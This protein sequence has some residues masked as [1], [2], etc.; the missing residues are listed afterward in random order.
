[1]CGAVC[2]H[3]FDYIKLRQMSVNPHAVA[4]AVVKGTRTQAS[5]RIGAHNT[6]APAGRRVRSRGIRVDDLVMRGV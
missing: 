1:M 2:V 3:L 4:A 6:R 5:A